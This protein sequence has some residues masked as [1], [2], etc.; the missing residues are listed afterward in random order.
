LADVQLDEQHASPGPPQP[1]H[2]PFEQVPVP[3]AIPLLTHRLPLQQPPWLQAPPSQ[4][5]SFG[6][7]HA[8]HVMPTLAY[9]HTLPGFAHALPAQQGWSVPPQAV[10]VP[11]EQ[12]CPPGHWEPAQQG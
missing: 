3:Q 4:Q 2:E 9:Q 12:T 8:W 5:G 7:P 6:P 1:P 10:Q 11:P